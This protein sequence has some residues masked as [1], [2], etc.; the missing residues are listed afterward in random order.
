MITDIFSQNIIRILLLFS[1][2][3]GSKYNRNEIKQKTKLNNVLLDNALN[4]LLNNQLLE[5]EKRLYKL[6]FNNN[7][8]KEFIEKLRK[9]HIRFNEIPLKVFFIL[10]DV[11]ENLLK[12]RDI[13][14]YLFGS[15]SK[16]I[17]NDKSDIDLAIITSQNKESI[18]KIIKKIEIKHKKIIEC[19]FFEKTDLKKNEPL[20]KEIL[21]NGI[22]L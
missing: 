9:E 15:Y 6:N 5:K 8:T 1:I 10:M 16:L 11:S 13:E 14:I 18:Q 3:P 22:K 12:K 21:K 19:H 4:Q 17:F 20:I 7:L 2:S